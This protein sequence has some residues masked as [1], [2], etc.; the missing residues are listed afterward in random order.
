MNPPCRVTIMP[1]LTTL[2][3][4]ISQ[5]TSPFSVMWPARPN[6]LGWCRYHMTKACPVVRLHHRPLVPQ[7]AVS[8]PLLQPWP[9][10][11]GCLNCPHNTGQSAVYFTRCLHNSS[12]TLSICVS[13]LR[14]NKKQEKNHYTPLCQPNTTHLAN[15]FSKFYLAV[16]PAASPL[17]F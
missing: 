14:L 7:H 16:S 9:I 5:S 12:R 4:C 8:Q 2:R 17:H 1:L 13:S 11:S 15:L 6:Q 3:I 10:G